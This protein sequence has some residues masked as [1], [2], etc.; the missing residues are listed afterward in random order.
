MSR[1]DGAGRAGVRGSSGCAA[2]RLVPNTSHGVDQS[3]SGL[4]SV[5]RKPKAASVH[6]DPDRSSTKK[7]KGGLLRS[8]QGGR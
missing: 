2:M 1:P 7:P 5:R 4:V 8:D 6:P 3:G